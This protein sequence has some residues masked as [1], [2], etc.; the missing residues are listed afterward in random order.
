MGQEI[1]CRKA[2]EAALSHQKGNYAAVAQEAA[3]FSA[4]TDTAVLETYNWKV[5]RYTETNQ[6]ILM[7]MGWKKLRG[8]HSQ[9]L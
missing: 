2:Y 4:P 1:L 7:A 3:T 8:K 5:N 9:W 6:L